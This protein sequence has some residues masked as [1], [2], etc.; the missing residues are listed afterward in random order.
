MRRIIHLL[1]IGLFLPTLHA[2][3]GPQQ[4]FDVANRLY[5]R[6]QYDSA[7]QLYQQLIDQ[8]YINEALFFNA[9][10]AYYKTNRVGEAVYYFE[11]ALQL[12]PGNKAAQHNLAL[13]RQRVVEQV[14]LL[15]QVFFQQWWNKLL[16]LHSANGWLIGSILLFWLLAGLWGAVYWGA[17]NNKWVRP[18]AYLCLLLFV[19]Y[20]IRAYG[21][22]RDVSG[23]KQAIVMNPVA[24][25]YA[26]PDK[27]S[28]VLFEVHEGIKVQLLDATKE[29]KKVR[30]EDG[31]TGWIPAHVLKTL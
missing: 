29:W 26:A 28:G 19:I 10:N 22:Y 11:K 3:A 16:Q 9:G 5:T 17:I 4:Q 1:T 25:V 20:S 27:G 30:L 23:K 7:A 6:Q 24:K 15:P 21:C 31:K 2:G 14:D 13:A 12:D 8:G 18:M